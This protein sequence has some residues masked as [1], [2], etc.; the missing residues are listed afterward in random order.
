MIFR[1]LVIED[2]RRLLKAVNPVYETMEFGATS[3]IRGVVIQRAGTR[4]V[5]RKHYD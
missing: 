1:Q 2:G 5:H 3:S 4:R